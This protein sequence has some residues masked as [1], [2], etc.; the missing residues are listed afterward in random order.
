MIRIY[1]KKNDEPSGHVFKSHKSIL[2]DKVAILSWIGFV[3][4]GIITEAEW[5]HSQTLIS[6][7]FNLQIEET[8][9]DGRCKRAKYMKPFSWKTILEPSINK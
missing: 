5:A 4:P 8:Y 7:R 1:I 2:K 6:E 3:T 9:I